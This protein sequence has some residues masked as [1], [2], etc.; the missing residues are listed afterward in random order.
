MGVDF[1]LVNWSRA[2]FALTA[3]YHWIFVPLTLGLSFIVA[4]M[5]TI[6][7]KTGS[8]E[9]KKI[10]KFW[11][12]LFGIN[13]A[14]GVATGIILEFEFG[15]NWSNYSWFVGDIFGA[16]LAIEGL[17]AF[18]MES[19][20]IAVMFF[21]W[22]RVSKKFHMLS[23]WF[24]AIGTNLSAIWILIANAWMQHPAGMQFNPDI[25]RNEMVNFADVVFNPTAV[26]KFLHS[27][28]QAY[29][30]AAIFVMGV[31]AWLILKNK[32]VLLAKK[33]LLVSSIFGFLA[34]LFVVFTG[35]L[36]A[37]DVAQTQP[38]KFASM[39]GL[40]KGH[41]GQ[42]IVAFGI[43]NG[44]KKPGDGQDEFHFVIK[45]PKLLSL[46]ATRSI[47]GFVPGIE[48]LY[49]GN[50]QHNIEPLTA[51]IEKGK[52]AIDALKQYKQAK[53]S[54]DEELK[55]KSLEEFRKYEKYMGY[56]Y[57]EKP[58]EL[59]PPVKYTFYSF[60][61]MVLLGSWFVIITFI[62]MLFSIKKNV[63][64]KK[65]WLKA[66][67]WTIPLVWLATELGWITAEVG[68]QP[69]IITELL[70]VKVATSH[71]SVGNVQLTFFLF[72]T[73]FTLLLIAEVK[74]ML[75]Q[76]KKGI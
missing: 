35:D 19:T 52:K 72:L 14:I 57:F 22:N 40:Y 54:G 32:N 9:W 38:M 69:W 39:E 18:F 6:Y 46:L 15:T 67:T 20:F 31:S 75:T 59:I 68:R 4:I 74:I 36:H 10:T 26:T 48:D 50:E 42:S 28:S 37:E 8:E 58:D 61:L 66:T 23:S 56:S 5:H 70:P 3:I 7:F 49:F 30:L 13:F 51:K 21:G 17:L 71:L 55:A 33:S 64:T 43:I 47:D 27:I 34:S 11:M 25:A 65:F 63:E 1:A 76:I 41:E 16:P 73:I 2:Q 60:H 29:L 12:K 45:I 62:M 53:E 24:T 44:D